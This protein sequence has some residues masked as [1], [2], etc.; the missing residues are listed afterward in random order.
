MIDVT[1][2]TIIDTIT[3]VCVGTPPLPPTG[4]GQPW[5]LAAGI[6]LFAAGVLA[7]WMGRR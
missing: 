4:V 6:A 1:D 5:A 2:C 7:T 3:T